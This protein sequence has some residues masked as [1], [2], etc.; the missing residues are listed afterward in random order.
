MLR[1]YHNKNW[2]ENK[3]IKE[4]LSMCRIAEICNVEYYIINNWIHRLNIP[5]RSVSEG[6]HLALAN[7][8][9]L[10]EKAIE[11]IN[12]ELLGDGCIACRHPYSARI[13]YTSQ[14][15]EY[16]QYI[17]NTLESFEIEGG[18]I[19]KRYNKKNNCCSYNYF[20]YEYE[21]LL[22]IKKQWYPNGK[23]IVPKNIKLTPLTLRQWYIGDGHLAYLQ[24]GNPMIVLATNGFLVKDVEWLTEQLNKINFKATIRHSNNNIGISTYSTKGFLD[25]I[26]RPEVKCY[27]YKWDYK[28]WVTK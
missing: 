11:W 20:S 13:I 24:K 28:K 10:S 23:K 19:R 18:K 6:T 12:G 14:Y 25:Y 15:L 2:L 1:L 21:E 27:Q 4:K 16:C 17:K 9:N 22:P 7:H 5:A 8:C 3:Y 26:G